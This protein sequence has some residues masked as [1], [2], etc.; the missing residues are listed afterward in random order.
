MILSDNETRVDLLNNQAIADTIIALLLRRPQSSITIG[1]HGDWGAGKSSILEM[2]EEGFSNKFDSYAHQLPLQKVESAYSGEPLGVQALR[3]ESYSQT[4]FL[5]LKF[6]GWRF[7]GFEDAKIAL[8]EG[9][10]EEILNKRPLTEQVKQAARNVF[11]RID[12]LKLAKKAGGLAVTALTGIP[13]P[14]KIKTATAL[15]KDFLS[16]TSQIVSAE[17][18]NKICQESLDILKPKDESANVPQE[19][20]AFHEAFD[21]LLQT[22]GVKQLIVL[23][24]DLDRCLPDTAIETLE[25]IRLFLFTSKTAFI[26]AADEGMIEYAVRKHFPGLNESSSSNIYAR[27]YLEK[28]IQVPFRIPALGDVETKT[29]ISLLL[30]GSKVGENSDIFAKTIEAAREKL[31]KPWL[32]GPL[33]RDAIKDIFQD[34]M[35]NIQDELLLSDQI[36]PILSQGTKGNPRQIKRFLNALLL[37]V[38]IAHARGFAEDIN[39]QTLAKLML[40]ERFYAD[41]FDKVVDSSAI[42]E[43]GQSILIQALERKYT[44]LPSPD[45]EPAE[46]AVPSQGNDEPDPNIDKAA[47]RDWLSLVPPLTDVDLRPYLFL[48]KD[49]KDYFGPLS[50]LGH[51]S[52]ITGKLMGTDFAVAGLSAQ[53]KQLTPVEAANIF[54]VISRKI[55]SR[56]EFKKAP[57][58]IAGLTA[59]LKNFTN[60][61][62]SALDFLESIPPSKSGAWVT[63]WE[64][65]FSEPMSKGRYKALSRKWSQEGSRALQTAIKASKV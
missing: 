37:R 40:A 28:L 42:N 4:D 31:K 1:V 36:S 60:L 10:V 57:E 13:L 2:I 38:N 47:I 15:V 50:A 58:G 43:F 44:Q 59:L 39:I 33:E 64:H 52:E 24:D 51:L 11:K 32:S 29:Y 3:C 19:V 26:V 17:S 54:S 27:N 25:A 63:K 61:G 23:I 30:I 46:D 56:G 22:A 5:C 20:R 34:A 16:D 14:D 6:N 53:I 41:L 62:G 21:E 12:W 65:L 45:E 48:V 7:Q 55:I 8:L 35:D 49:R 9:I 18:L